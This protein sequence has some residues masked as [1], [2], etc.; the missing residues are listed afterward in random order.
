M[1]VGGPTPVSTA[2]LNESLLTRYSVRWETTG[3]SIAWTIREL[4]RIKR[5]QYRIWLVYSV[6]G[7][8]ELE[9]RGRSF[10]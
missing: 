8:E 7:V 9:K 5:L 4:D 1:R 10:I 6:V 3:G 2:L